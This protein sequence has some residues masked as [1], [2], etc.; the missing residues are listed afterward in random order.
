M[1]RKKVYWIGLAIVILAA[2]GG[3]YAYFGSLS[4]SAQ[5]AEEDVAPQTTSVRQGDIVVS[6]TGAG[7]VVAATEVQLGFETTGQ[8]TEL[9]VRVG[10]EVQAGDVL[11]RLDDADAA[12]SVANA[13]I[14]FVQAAVRTDPEATESG[15]S[16]NA[17]SIEQ[18][19]INLDVAQARLDALHNWEPDEDE[20]AQADANLE[21]A[22]ASYQAALGNISASSNNASIAQINLQAAERDLAATQANYD[23]AWDEARD[24]ETYWNEPVCGP[25]EQEPCTGLTWQQRIENDRTST[26]NALARAQDNLAI[27][28]AS[29]NASASSVN[30]SGSTSAQSNILAAE[31][32]LEAAQS[33]P[34]DE[35]IEAAE[36]AVQQ[37]GLALQQAMV[38]QEI[39]VLNLAQAEL[40]LEAAQADLAG[41]VLLAPMDG[42]IMSIEAQVG[43]NVGT[44]PFISLA[45]LDQ[46]LLEAFFDETDL[47]KVGVG[48]EVEVIFDALPNDVFVG[49][50]VQVDPQLLDVGGITAVRAIVQLDTDSFSKPQTLPVGLNATAEVIGGRAENAML[51][52]VEALR[53]LS[54]GEYAVFV[55]E[56]GEPQLRMVEVGLMDFS[57]AEIL[58][59]LEPGETVTTGIVETQ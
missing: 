33:G 10:D 15:V 58:S 7:T 35:E 37:A 42:T 4:S 40:Y 21:A 57:F 50:V 56:N 6:A 46:P 18:A 14:Q 34:D 51:V 28:Q 43:E 30:S 16:S 59:G 9:L 52:P 41:T 48:Y 27:A 12:Q 32:A 38:N 45:D 2:A 36:T 1:F 3:A 25:G 54:P 26:D 39:D 23:N 20:I 5:A 44:S 13:E 49:H 17:I 55:M 29:Y 11:A 47:D 53:E 31:L 19:Q 8:L 22:Q 24:W